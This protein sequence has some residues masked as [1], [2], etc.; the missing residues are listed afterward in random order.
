MQPTGY[1]EVKSSDRDQWRAQA[2]SRL[3]KYDEW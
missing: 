3:D 1:D 2:L